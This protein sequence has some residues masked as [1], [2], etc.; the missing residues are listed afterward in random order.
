MWQKLFSPI[1]WIGGLI[2]A[3]L[4][5]APASVTQWLASHISEDTAAWIASDKGRWSFAVTAAFVLFT[6]QRRHH[7]RLEKQTQE[8]GERRSPTLTLPTMPIKEVAEYLRD[9]SA[10][11]WRQ[12]RKGNTPNG[13]FREAVSDEIRRAASNKEVRLIATR[14]N[15]RQSIEL[16]PAF[17]EDA[18]PDPDRIWDERNEVWLA[19]LPDAPYFETFRLGRAPRADIIKAWPSATRWLR[20]SEVDPDRETVGAAC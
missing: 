9:E 11:G 16:D 7:N 18:K 1:G 14:Q 3:F 2:L 20:L 10:W 6:T 12:R 17:W 5:L 15:S 13:S 4:G 8:E 19:R